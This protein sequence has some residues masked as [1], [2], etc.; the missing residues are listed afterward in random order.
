MNSAR[1]RQRLSVV[2]A[3]ATLAG[4][5]VFHASSA[6]RAFCAAVSA[7]KGG[8]G[9]R[10]ISQTSFGKPRRA[11]SFDHLNGYCE[12]RHWNFLLKVSL[13]RRPRPVERFHSSNPAQ[14]PSW[15]NLEI[16][17]RREESL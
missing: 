16:E 10:F 14:S 6:I 15:R 3:S 1:L 7:V 12:K 2:Y 17:Q 9:G 13:R 4:S 5:R 8:S 11:A